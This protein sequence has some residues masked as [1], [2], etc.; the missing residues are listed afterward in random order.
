VNGEG[1]EGWFEQTLSNHEAGITLQT[2]SFEML[3]NALTPQ[4][5]LRRLHLSTP[6]TSLG[7]LHPFD[8]DEDSMDV[9]WAVGSDNAFSEHLESG[10]QTLFY[11]GNALEAPRPPTNV[12]FYDGSLSVSALVVIVGMS[13]LFV[14]LAAYYGYRW[15]SWL[16]WRR[17]SAEDEMEKDEKT[18]LMNGRD[19]VS[20][21]SDSKFIAL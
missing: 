6:L 3:R 7:A 16:R 11:E 20:G 2:K 17:F 4:D 21:H 9:I 12:W 19:A 18:P 13:A 15:F 14:A 1:D 10:S 5:S 8:V